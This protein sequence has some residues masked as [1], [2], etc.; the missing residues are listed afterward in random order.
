MLVRALFQI[1]HDS[2]SASRFATGRTKA[3]R[4]ICPFLS[5]SSS[6]P[7]A[8]TIS[9]PRSITKADSSPKACEKCSL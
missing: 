4:G 5:R 1:S 7:S 8:G 2:V 9:P 3:T 6:T